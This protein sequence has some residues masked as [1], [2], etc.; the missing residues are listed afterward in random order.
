[1]IKLIPVT[2]S[3]TTPNVFAVEIS[4]NLCQGYPVDEL[5]TA[6]VSV[7]NSGVSVAAGSTTTQKVTFAVTITYQP[8]P[9]S[10]ETKVKTFA[11][12]VLVAAPG[13]VA[14]TPTIG[15]VTT[16]ATKVC[17]NR[18]SGVKILTNLN[19]AYT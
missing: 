5:P 2:M 13:S 16:S 11:E 10:T 18:A 17:G 3:G 4:E 9:M 15:S 14:I 1:M 12:T 19:V 6:I 7:V 8:C